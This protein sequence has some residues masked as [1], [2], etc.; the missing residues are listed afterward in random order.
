MDQVLASCLLYLSNYEAQRNEKK[1]IETTII[2]TV[3]FLG[4]L[5]KENWGIVLDL[6]TPGNLLDLGNPDYEDLAA[7]LGDNFL[8]RYRNGPGRESNDNIKV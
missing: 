1:I 6:I 2:T 7:C 3:Q 8:A 5:H 4:M